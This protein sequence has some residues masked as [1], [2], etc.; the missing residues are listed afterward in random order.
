MAMTS[1]EICG[2]FTAG[3]RRRATSRQVQNSGSPDQLD[4]ESDSILEPLSRPFPLGL[5]GTPGHVGLNSN[6]Q[7][8]AGRV[9]YHRLLLRRVVISD[10][11]ATQVRSF[12]RGLLRQSLADSRPDSLP[13]QSIPIYKSQVHT[14]SRTFHRTTALMVS[15]MA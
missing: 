10:M 8:Q 13:R 9:Q 11:F 7:R 1:L 14:P 5:Y 12:I 15:P 4:S 3:S 6:T 2:K